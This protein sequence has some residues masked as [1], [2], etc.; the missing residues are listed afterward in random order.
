[1]LDKPQGSHCIRRQLLPVSHCAW[2]AGKGSLIIS[3]A[4]NHASIVAG[5]RGSGAKV[6]VGR[7]GAQLSARAFVRYPWRNMV[8]MTNAPQHANMPLRGTSRN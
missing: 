6:K 2:H 5:T 3:D 4:L 7:L 8:Q 1:M